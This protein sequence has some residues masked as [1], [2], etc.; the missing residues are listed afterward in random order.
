MYEPV[1]QEKNNH[2]LDLVHHWQEE[3]P[4]GNAEIGFLKNEEDKLAPF[5]TWE[6]SAPR[7]HTHERI[8][9]DVRKQT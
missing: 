4:G 6:A 2:I 9:T 7:N 1:L 3:G 5:C 8:C